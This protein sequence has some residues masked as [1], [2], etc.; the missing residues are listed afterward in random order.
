MSS[1][2][3]EGIWTQ[4][5]WR[6]CGPVSRRYDSLGVG[7][8]T[9]D[10]VGQEEAWTKALDSNNVRSILQ[11]MQPLSAKGNMDG[12]SQV[13]TL[14]NWVENMASA[15]KRDLLSLC[16][17]CCQG[18]WM[19]LDQHSLTRVHKLL[20]TLRN[21]LLLAKWGRDHGSPGVEVER[22]EREHWALQRHLWLGQL[23]QWWGI[24]G[25]LP[26]PPDLQERMRLAHVWQELDENRRRA[27]QE[28]LGEEVPKGECGS[29]VQCMMALLEKEHKPVWVSGEPGQQSYP[30]PCLQDLLRLVLVPCFDV[31]LVHAILM[32][33]LLDLGHLLQCKDDLL[34]SF[35]CA[36]SLPPGFCHQV[37][38]LWL[39]DQ[40]QISA[41]IDLLLSPKSRHP[42]LM[43][44]HWPIIQFLLRSRETRR[45]H[46]YLYV[47]RPSVK[48]VQDF[49]LHVDVL[50]QNRCIR[51]AWGLLRAGQLCGDN[52]NTVREQMKK[53]LWTGPEMGTVALD[54][55]VPE[56]FSDGSC[57]VA[58]TQTLKKGPGKMLGAAG[59]RCEGRPPQPL[60]SRLFRF[61]GTDTLSSERV[62][63][64]LR[65]SVSEL[66]DCSWHERVSMQAVWQQTP[67]DTGFLFSPA[68]LQHTVP[69]SC[70]LPDGFPVQLSSTDEK[71]FSAVEPPAAQAN[72]R[73]AT[74]FVDGSNTTSSLFSQCCITQAVLPGHEFP[75]LPVS[76]TAVS[77]SDGQCEGCLHHRAL[78]G[79]VSSLDA[80][81]PGYPDLMLTLEGATDP[82]PVNSLSKNTAEELLLSA[83]CVVEDSL[84]RSTPG[85]SLPSAG[86]TAGLT[87]D[88]TAEG[89]RLRGRL[90][91]P[92]QFYSNEDNQ[93]AAPDSL[94][95]GDCF[96][97]ADVVEKMVNTK[98]VPE[99]I[100]S[101][102]KVDVDVICGVKTAERKA[103][104]FISQD[105]VPTGVSSFH[106]FLDLKPLQRVSD[107]QELEEQ[108]EGFR[109]D[110]Q[111][112]VDQPEILTC[113]LA[114]G[115]LGS[116]FDFSR[117]SSYEDRSYHGTSFQDSHD[118]GG[119]GGKLSEWESKGDGWVT[120]WYNKPFPLKDSSL[121]I[122]LR[123]SSYPGQLLVPEALL[124]GRASPGHS[125]QVR[126]SEVGQ[127]KMRSGRSSPQK[128]AACFRSATARLG[129]CKLRSWWKQALE[130]R[131]ASTGL[132]PA[133]NQFYSTAARY[134]DPVLVPPIP[135]ME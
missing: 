86:G 104:D 28:R 67:Q 55:E 52:V 1:Q 125:P 105:P 131:R 89:R 47:I 32:Y 46:Q 101:N 66:D 118:V 122:P 10:S 84:T 69:G 59:P 64:L 4:E 81:V 58:P 24:M 18:L 119:L 19:Y 109:R 111:E 121:H 78:S 72:G 80:V 9:T 2:P 68:V 98:E 48:S 27:R 133:A 83:A 94:L 71:Q 38:G 60:S 134:T 7:S 21:L 106:S 77:L 74:M 57:S 76:D 82:I 26:S 114:E 85:D 102:A 65:D 53:K 116:H 35:S 12:N 43:Q 40:G 70:P 54:K 25:F 49:M 115:T 120:V 41:S 97:S 63:V 44:L 20:Q 99:D 129:H 92:P 8:P 56:L 87:E 29:L 34:K 30:P 13:V 45:A 100:G 6:H 110:S 50:L 135:S 36:F 22:W 112:A 31:L 90:N 73:V 33:F 127:S 93:A 42:W 91:L 61:Q 5:N 88:F 15:S 130:L 14:C 123:R 11:C 107:S 96:L 126:L 117:C 124:S 95:E 108:A 16:F 3:F 39:L 51:E 132:P 113:T 17:S 79:S 75:L 128:E 23:V 103:K 37:K 62:F